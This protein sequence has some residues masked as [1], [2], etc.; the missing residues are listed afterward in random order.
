MVFELTKWKC[1]DLLGRESSINQSSELD[2]NRA[3]QS[4]L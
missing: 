2:L 4:E 1:S 3:P